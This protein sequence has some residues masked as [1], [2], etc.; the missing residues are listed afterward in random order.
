MIDW[1]SMQVVP[2]PVSG[3][4]IT[5]Y[6]AALDKQGGVEAFCFRITQPQPYPQLIAEP[7]ATTNYYNISGVLNNPAV[8]EHIKTLEIDFSLNLDSY[9]TPLDGFYL[10]GLLAKMLLNGVWSF[11]G[12]PEEG[13]IMS[14]M[15][16]GDMVGFD[17]PG[18][19]AVFVCV[20][21]CPGKWFCNEGFCD[22]FVIL[23]DYRQQHI[24]MLCHTATD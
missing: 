18:G 12:T 9:W 11:S 4:A 20:E 8:A 15:A 22:Y 1:K 19:I 14:V 5:S 6:I 16:A 3:N 24:W 21:N 17:N 7:G 23:F 13:K 2:V 10:D